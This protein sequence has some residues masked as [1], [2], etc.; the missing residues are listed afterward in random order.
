MLYQPIHSKLSTSWA[1]FSSP[2]WEAV[3]ESSQ[4]SVG[5]LPGFTSTETRRTWC[6]ASSKGFTS[7]SLVVDMKGTEVSQGRKP[8]VIWVSFQLHHSWRSDEVMEIK[9]IS[10]PKERQV[11][12]LWTTFETNKQRLGHYS[13]KLSYRLLTWCKRLHLNRCLFHY[14]AAF[15][16]QRQSL[17]AGEQNVLEL[18]NAHHPRWSS[19]RAAESTTQTFRASSRSF[20]KWTSTFG[21]LYNSMSAS[22]IMFWQ[23]QWPPGVRRGGSERGGGGGVSKR[24]GVVETLGH[25]LVEDCFEFNNTITF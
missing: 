5:S 20:S 17:G 13:Q 2:R 6:P 9:S 12:Y 15:I 11:K 7:T 19:A 23:S 21:G 16:W 4:T 22:L 18:F 25:F 1:S 8:V 14:P 3:E 10:L 24:L